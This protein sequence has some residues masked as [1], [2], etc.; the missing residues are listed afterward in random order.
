MRCVQLQHSESKPKPAS[1]HTGRTHTAS[2]EARARATVAATTG[3]G[4]DMLLYATLVT[5]ARA[6]LRIAIP[7]SV[8]LMAFTSL[9]GIGVR[10][11]SG[12]FADPVLAQNLFGNW[13][14]AAPVVA[15]GAPL[16]AVI[17]RYLRREPT[18]I[19][20][21]TLCVVQYV[22]TCYAEWESMGVRLLL[23]SMASILAMNGVFHLMYRFGDWL[24]APR[25]P[26]GPDRTV[27]VVAP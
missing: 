10:Y 24:M 1:P 5:V 7:T 2:E 13:L 6:D 3:I 17:V 8:V 15:L 4:V 23:V 14:A 16:G 21:S 20:V 11:A 27:R 12:A 19:V 18:L 25:G 9:V 26:S 22:W